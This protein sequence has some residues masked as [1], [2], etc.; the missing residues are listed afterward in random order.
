MEDEHV[1]EFFGVL[2]KLVKGQPREE[3][4][5][6]MVGPSA[7]HLALLGDVASKKLL[8]LAVLDSPPQ[9]TAVLNGCLTLIKRLIETKVPGGGEASLADGCKA[10]QKARASKIFDKVATKMSR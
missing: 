10:I 6:D 4:S 9:N 1:G 8:S 3:G 7:K 5:D 2:K